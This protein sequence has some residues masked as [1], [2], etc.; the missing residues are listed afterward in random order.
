MVNIDADTVSVEILKKGSFPVPIILTIEYSDGS[1]ESI[2]RNI[3]VWKDSDRYIHK[4]ATQKEI[5]KIR[6]DY[7]NIPDKD[8]S[9]NFYERD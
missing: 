8:R 3:E 2:K 6:L 1:T 9:N 4:H 5:R 7:K